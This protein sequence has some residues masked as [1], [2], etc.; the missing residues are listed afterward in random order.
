M[1][2]WK[3][4][5]SGTVLN[6]TFLFFSPSFVVR[7]HET[8][9]NSPSV[10]RRVVMSS[11][12]RGYFNEKRRR[13]MTPMRRR[14]LRYQSTAGRMSMY[15]WCVCIIAGVRGEKENTTICRDNNMCMY[16]YRRGWCDKTL[17]TKRFSRCLTERGFVEERGVKKCSINH[18]LIVYRFQ[19]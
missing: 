13:S 4:R 9:T 1:C 11:D 2:T 6:N 3:S 10:F 12:S 5:T 19:E 7:R 8:R 14:T 16:C 18:I 17:E 15:C